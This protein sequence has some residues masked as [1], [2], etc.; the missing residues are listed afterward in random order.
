MTP[1]P[2]VKAEDVPPYLTYDQ[3][4][5]N[6][7]AYQDSTQYVADP[8]SYYNTPSCVDA[9]NIIR[10]MRSEAEVEYQ[11]DLTCQIPPQEFRVSNPNVFAIMDRYAS[12]Q[13][14]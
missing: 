8:T 6:P 5:N 9:A 14:A 1:G 11:N 2:D 4:Y 12:P 7:W 3:P 13:R 10:T